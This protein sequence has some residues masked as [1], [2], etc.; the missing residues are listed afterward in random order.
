MVLAAFAIVMAGCGSS[1]SSTS[2]TAPLTNIKKRVLVSNEAGVVRIIDASNDTLSLKT[3]GI[4]APTK[5]LKAGGFTLIAQNTTAVAIFNNSTEVIAFNTP[6][7]DIPSDIALSPDGSTAWVA[8]RNVGLVQ[9]ISTSTG[10]VTANIS[11]P[12]AVRLSMSPTGT[13]LLVFTD[14]LKPQAN[15]DNFW[16]IDTNS[17]V[18]TAN[19]AASPV[20]APSLDQPFTAIFNGSETQALILSCGK[21]CGGSGVGSNVSKIDF[22]T[23]SAPSTISVIPVLAATTGTI[24]GTSL[25]VAGTP[26]GSPFGTL[27]VIDTGSLAIVG[28]ATQITDGI[29]LNMAVASNSRLY[30]GARACTRDHPAL[31]IRWLVV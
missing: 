28:A 8:E 6:T 25:F 16:V 10:A 29:H 5:M 15:A 30:I 24:N 27:Q 1:S 3:V 19:K 17:V 2:Q 14:T 22:T 9:A 12:N 13:R 20:A 4:G 23:P 21:P 18:N 7:A 31:R 11:I 26:L